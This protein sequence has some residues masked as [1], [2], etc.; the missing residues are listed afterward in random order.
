MKLKVLNEKKNQL[1]NRIESKFEINHNGEKTPS[2]DEVRSL[3][4]ATSGSSESL[5]SINSVNPIFGQGKSFGVA[6]I[7]TKKEDL[8]KNEPKYILK[9]SEK[10]KEELKVEENKSEEKP[11]EELAPEDTKKEEEK[12]EKDK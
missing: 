1:F 2:R 10:K 7:Y 3:V 11:A 9:R 12:T 8:E 6:H 5:I 4:S